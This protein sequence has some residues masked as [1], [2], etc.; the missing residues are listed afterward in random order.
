MYL[1]FFASAGFYIF[2]YF[3]CI[4]QFFWYLVYFKDIPIQRWNIWLL[5]YT[6]FRFFDLSWSHF[7]NLSPWLQ[8]KAPP[9]YSCEDKC[10][11]LG[12][13]AWGNRWDLIFV[14]SPPKMSM[15]QKWDAKKKAR[16]GWSFWWCTWRK[17][18][19]NEANYVLI[20]KHR[21]STQTFGGGF[22]KEWSG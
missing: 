1:T 5:W 22:L 7:P 11:D 19:V 18:A 4:L 15:A 17:N 2:R 21:E 3:Q 10:L 8:V 6:W 9:P 14:M 12:F 16:F 13:R 20:F